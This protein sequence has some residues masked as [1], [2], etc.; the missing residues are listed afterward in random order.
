MHGHVGREAPGS[1][2]GTVNTGATRMSQSIVLDSVPALLCLIAG[3]SKK[4]ESLDA[5]GSALTPTS[6]AQSVG[7][8]E[9][10]SEFVASFV[11]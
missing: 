4:N 6:A 1:I 2:T 10:F 8:V 5:N 3:Q 9:F 7:I 11:D